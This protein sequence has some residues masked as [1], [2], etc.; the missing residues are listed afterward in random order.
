MDHIE[1]KTTLRKI[2]PTKKGRSQEEGPF[3]HQQG[4]EHRVHHQHSQA[5]PW[6]EFPEVF[7]SH[8]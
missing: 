1:P 6:S 5:D 2:A 8:T 3:C 4:S 7:P